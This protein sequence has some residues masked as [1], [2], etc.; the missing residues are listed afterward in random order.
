MGVVEEPVDRW[1]GQGLGHDGVEASP[2]EVAGDGGAALF[3]GG[4]D[5]AIEGFGAVLS[6]GQGADAID[7]D[8]VGTINSGDDFLY[9]S[10]DLRS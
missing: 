6:D 3:V 10:V 4:V 5:S 1:S 2:V 8:E 9:R 7:N